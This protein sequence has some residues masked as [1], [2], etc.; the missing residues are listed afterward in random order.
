MGPTK[1]RFPQVEEHQIPP[2]AHFR[3]TYYRTDGIHQR[4]DIMLVSA[5]CSARVVD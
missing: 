4:S 2:L 5:G 3:F 1:W